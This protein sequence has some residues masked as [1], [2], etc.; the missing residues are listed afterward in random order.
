M[1]RFKDQINRILCSGINHAA[2]FGM[3]RLCLENL[4]LSLARDPR[5]DLQ[6]EPAAR[7]PKQT[8]P[9]RTRNG[10]FLGE[11]VLSKKS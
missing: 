9:V 5:L 3:C 2:V 1:C 4:H 11:I 6:L 8:W 7:D 10:A